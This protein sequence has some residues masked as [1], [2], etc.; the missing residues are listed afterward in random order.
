MMVWLCVIG[1][2]PG[3]FVFEKLSPFAV[4]GKCQFL[5]PF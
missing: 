3:P 2:N 1:E 5:T 4:D